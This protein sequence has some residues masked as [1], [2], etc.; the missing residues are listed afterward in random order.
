M[1]LPPLKRKKKWAASDITTA[2]ME[3][4]GRVMTIDTKKHEQ[5]M[6]LAEWNHKNKEYLEAQKSEIEIS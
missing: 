6:T 2:K 5:S 4:L 1:M 3:E